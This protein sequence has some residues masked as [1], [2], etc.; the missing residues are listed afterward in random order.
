MV[1]EDKINLLA[2]IVPR[3][4]SDDP[5]QEKALEDFVTGL[6]PTFDVIEKKC[7]S[8]SEADVQLAGTELL[9]AEILKPGRSTKTEFASW[10]AALTE[11]DVLDVLER[12]KSFKKVAV[13]ALTQMRENRQAE[14]D[15]I[16]AEKKKF[17]EQVEK[18]RA[19][20]TIELNIKNGKMELKKKP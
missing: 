16:E 19:E 14:L 18:A 12:R 4:G 20:R 1:P 8:L 15:R 3:F 11:A 10:V 5:A 2:H 17:E 6:E 7:P 13:D 9:A